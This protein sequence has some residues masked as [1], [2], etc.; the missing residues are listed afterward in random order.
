MGDQL[1]T[2]RLALITDPAYATYFGGPANVTAAKV[3]LVNRITQIYEDDTAIRLMLVANNDLLN[4]DTAALATG[5]NGPCGTAACFTPAQISLLQQ[6]RPDP[7]RD[8]PDHRGEQLRHRPPRRGRAGG[9][10]AQLGVVGRSAKAQGCTGVT[11]PTGDF[12]AVDYVAHEMGHQ[13]AGNHTFNGSQ[14]ACSGGNRSAANSVEPGSG[15]SIMAYAGICAADNLQPHSDPY[16]SQ[17]SFQEVVTYTSSNQAAINEVQNVSLR[18]FD[19]NGDSFT[20]RYNGND[21]IPIVRGTNYTATDIASAIQGIAGWPGG[22]VTVSSFGS[23]AG[24]PNDEGFQVTFNTAPLAGTNVSALSL[25]NVVNMTG[26]VGETDKGGAVDNKGFTIT[27]TSNSAPVVTA[28]AAFTIPLR[29]PF[30]LVGSATDADGDTLTYLWEQNDRGGASGTTLNNNTKV[31]GP[32]FRQFSTFAN[33]TPAG[34]LEYYSPGENAVTTDPRRIFPDMPQILANNTNAETGTCA[35]LDCFSEF[36]PTSS[37]TGFPVT[38][39]PQLHF[40][41]TVRDGSDGGGGVNSADTTLTLAPGTGPF[42]VTAPNTALTWTGSTMQ[43]V[44]WAV[45]GTSAAPVGATDV[46]I[47]LSLDGGLTW[48]HTLAASTPNDGTHTVLVPNVST[49]QARVMVGGLSN[50]FFDVSNVNFTIVAGLPVPVVT[51][52]APGGGAIAPFGGPVAPT[53]TVSATDA[54]SLGTALNASAPGLPAGLSLAVGTTTVGPPGAR[55]WTVAGNVTAAPG[56]YPVTV[57]VTDEAAGSGQT[58]FDIVVGKAPTTTAVVSSTNPSDLGQPATFTATVTTGTPAGGVPTGTVTFRDGATSLGTG[59][60]NGAGLA[61]LTTFALAVGS[62]SITAEYAGDANRNG[63]TSPTL[64]Q[65]VISP[66]LGF[67]TLAPCRV[68]DTR[69]GAPVGG[70]AL[71]GQVVRALAIAGNCGVPATARAVSVNVT[72]TQPTAAGNVRVYASGMPTPVVSTLNYAIGQTR[73][74]NAI[75][76]LSAGGAMDALATQTAG[77]TVELIVDVNGYFE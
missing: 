34:T 75:V 1:R 43:P 66:P 13:F 9:G 12:F 77:T 39:P 8:R 63:S 15:S 45:A 61:D 7:H 67:F 57:T 76:P 36:L 64:T 2:Y 22:T 19:V 74:N 50:I 24:A 3:T 26:F 72:V 18:S 14:S 27:P 40:R 65:N 54:D 35:N 55:T 60:L 25:T 32:L 37:Y 73:A 69:G 56:T 38:S 11:T 42:L 16:W 48:P 52:D 49:T 47:Y 20:I 17:R 58:S 44:T 62:H 29:T 53:L 71:S 59:T 30:A 41:L 70:P 28:P 68:V 31:D 4:L 23:A 5:A 51:N 46:A 10:I 21:S 6:P 33:V